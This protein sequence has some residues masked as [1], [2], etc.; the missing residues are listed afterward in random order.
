M[1]LPVGLSDIN[2]LAVVVAGVAHML[3]GM[4]WFSPRLF[5]NAWAEDT[6]KGLAPARRWLPAG[7]LGHQVIALALAVIVRLAGATTALV[8]IAVAVLVW[9]GFVVTLEIG[10]LIWEKI[11]FRLFAIRVGNHLV[12][13]GLAGAILALW[14]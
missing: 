5:G 14:R 8:G 12:A 2:L 6:G 11:P 3:V 1:S 4:A 7:V 9:L 13:L 10:E